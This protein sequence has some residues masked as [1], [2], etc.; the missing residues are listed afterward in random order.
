MCV[1]VYVYVYV[2]VCI[3]VSVY[4]VPSTVRPDAVG[5]LLQP[6]HTYLSTG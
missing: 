4:S 2:Y 6:R 5:I 3:C 1:C